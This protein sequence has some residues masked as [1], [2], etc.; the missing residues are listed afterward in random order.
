MT[1]ELT[2]G[3]ISL[4]VLGPIVFALVFLLVIAV[5]S[6]YGYKILRPIR[7]LHRWMNRKKG[8]SREA[9]ISANRSLAENNLLLTQE[10]RLLINENHR[11][12]MLISKI[13]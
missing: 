12:R 9:L 2:F 10:N 4:L 6:I 5:L 8:P 13:K 11:L 3:E 7:R 1:P